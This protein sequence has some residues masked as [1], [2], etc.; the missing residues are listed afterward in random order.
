MF[1][2]PSAPSG[3]T[4]GTEYLGCTEAREKRRACWDDLSSLPKSGIIISS[5]HMCDRAADP[6]SERIG[7]HLKRR[8]CACQFYGGWRVDPS[9]CRSQRRSATSRQSPP[10]PRWRPI[11]ACHMP[12]TKNN[13]TAEEVRYF[14]DYDKETG[15]LIRINTSKNHPHR[16][17]KVAGCKYSEGYIVVSVPGGRR[18]SAHRLIWLWV[19]G[20]WPKHEID[21]INGNRSDNRIE[22]L[23]D[24]TRSVNGENRRAADITNKSGILGAS[25][26]EKRK[27]Y[28]VVISVRGTQHFLG[29]FKDPEQARNAYITAK[30]K[31]HEGNTL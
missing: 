20:E 14:F 9:G 23:R 10:S 22:N 12:Q 31:L 8:F 30:R 24:V 11:E 3:L 2:A 5:R 15:N 18:F 21:H 17:N 16:L 27:C 1:N 29:L 19:Y 25:W 6:T 13:L 28:Q 26:L 4:D 7:A